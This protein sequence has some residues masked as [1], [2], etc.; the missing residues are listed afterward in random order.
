MIIVDEARLQR[1]D[2]SGRT[3]EE[4]LRAHY[5][6][7]WYSFE[8]FW[9]EQDWDNIPTFEKNPEES[10]VDGRLRPKDKSDMH[11][12]KEKL[13]RWLGERVGHQPVTYLEF[14]VRHGMS[15]GWMTEALTHPDSQLHGFDTFEGLPEDWVPYWGANGIGG[16]QAQ[17]A[18]KASA[19]Q[20]SDP[21]VTLHR[22][23]FQDILPGFLKENPPS[24]L[25]VINIDSDIYSSALYVL[26]MMHP[27][28]EPGDYVYMD[29]FFDLLNEFAAFN[30][31]VRS[32]YVK[33][34]YT[35]LGRAYDAFL[36]Q[37]AG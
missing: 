16:G 7:G 18:M 33:D 28:L 11:P 13:L 22:G 23:L 26:S 19:P 24:G 1:K 32:F 27:Y 37:Y 12:A 3:W 14:G 30:D 8:E 21:R 5:A 20:T 10:F 6:H 4:L 29:E 9:Q 31:Y 36:F 15:L 2:P 25:K 35:L 17:G 34:K